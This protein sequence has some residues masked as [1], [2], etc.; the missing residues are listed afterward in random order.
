MWVL[1]LMLIQEPRSYALGPR[2]V[3]PKGL[4]RFNVLKRSMVGCLAVAIFRDDLRLFSEHLFG[5]FDVLRSCRAVWIWHNFAI[6]WELSMR[7]SQEPILHCLAYSEQF[8]LFATGC[9]DPGAEEPSE[10]M[11]QV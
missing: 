6:L 2:F 9:M 10:R 8:G 4:E 5:V 11:E 7:S 3:I 1:V